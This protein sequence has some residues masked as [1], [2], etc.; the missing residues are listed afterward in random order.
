MKDFSTE[1]ILKHHV[2]NYF[3]INGKQRIKMPRKDEYVKFRNFERKIKF[4]FMICANFKS[5]LVPVDN[6]KKNPKEPYKNKYQKHVAC[7]Y[8]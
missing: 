5:I 7:S 1:E 6:G 4:P 3:K 8:G 2:K